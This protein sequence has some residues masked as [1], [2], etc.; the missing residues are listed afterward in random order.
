MQTAEQTNSVTIIASYA[1][2]VVKLKKGRPG[3][4]QLTTGF[5]QSKWREKAK[6]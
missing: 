5:H 3:V 2:T 6:L 4:S 1:Q